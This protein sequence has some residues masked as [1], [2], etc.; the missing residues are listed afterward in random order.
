MTLVLDTTHGLTL[1]TRLAQRRPE[2][3]Y[4]LRRAL[5][6]RLDALL[7]SAIA[8]AV[9]TGDPIGQIVA[10]LVRSA[11]DGVHAERIRELMPK[12]SVALRELGVVTAQQLVNAKRRKISDKCSDPADERRRSSDLASALHNFAIRLGDSGQ[13]EAALAAAEE[14]VTR[15]RDLTGALLP[16]AIERLAALE[17]EA[18]QAAEEDYR[19]S[20]ADVAKREE[21]PELAGALQDVAVRLANLGRWHEALLASAEAAQLFQD[22]R[23]ARPDAFESEWARLIQEIL[24]YRAGMALGS[25]G[26][27]EG[28]A[29]TAQRSAEHFR[30]R[31]RAQPDASSPDLALAL[32]NSAIRLG[33]AGQTKAAQAAAEEAV[34]RYRELAD[35]RSDAFGPDLAAALHTFAIRLGDAREAEAA[36]AAA[37]EAVTRYRE[38]ADAR[39]DVFG[40]E[41]AAALHTF[42]VRLGDAGEPAAAQ[43]AA[44]EAVTRY[45]DLAD[46]RPDVFGPE[47]AAALQTFAVRL[48][49]AG[50]PEAAQ[51]SAEEAVKR[52]RDLADTQPT[53]FGPGLAAA[54]HSFAVLLRN[55]GQPEAAQAAAEEAVTS[56]EVLALTDPHL[57]SDRMRIYYASYV[58]LSRESRRDPRLLARAL[59]DWSWITN[60]WHERAEP[61]STDSDVPLEV[62]ESSYEKKNRDA[63]ATMFEWL[64]DTTHDYL[65]SRGLHLG[66]RADVQFVER[67]ALL[68]VAQR[69]FDKGY[70]DAAATL[71]ERLLENGT[72]SVPAAAPRIATALFRSA[73]TL[74]SRI[75]Q[76]VEG[77]AHQVESVGEVE[78]AAELRR[79]LAARELLVIPPKL[80][81]WRR[82]L[83]L[84]PLS[85][86]E[87]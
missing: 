15:Y 46:A 81:W 80:S 41:L 77:L 32:H 10:E 38:L 1:L 3:T 58:Q 47:L 87:R 86:K 44:Q 11:P 61:N 71:Y 22:M 70:W 26:N 6:M 45:R 78:L 49:D 66:R 83:A 63:A 16:L 14:A 20:I 52:Y 29:E 64:L 25:A 73:A 23:V 48:G 62:A 43:A 31:A 17:P 57:F 82:M 35:M 9:E 75:R 51:A 12:R 19:N 42:A 53:A 18:R 30:E 85:P 69:S 28:A 24:K 76:R 36:Q 56:L 5:A 7:P 39:P 21:A 68:E 40:P 72:L 4:L 54:L 84:R 13:P 33:N 2:E 34:T 37:E 8:V 55:A 60:L 74:T 50:E 79:E 27:P 59:D 67:D 65:S